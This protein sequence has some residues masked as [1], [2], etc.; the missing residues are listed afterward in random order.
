MNKE[1]VRKTVV[2][3]LAL[4]L[5]VLRAY[6]TVQNA[7]AQETSANVNINIDV[8][9]NA[10]ISGNAE[11]SMMIDDS[12]GF[13][14]NQ[15]CEFTN[16]S[17]NKTI[18]IFFTQQTADISLEVKATLNKSTVIAYIEI[19]VNDAIQHGINITIHPDRWEQ[20]I[21]GKEADFFG[22]NK[23]DITADRSLTMWAEKHNDSIS[24]TC[25]STD[26]SAAAVTITKEALINIAA[27]LNCNIS[28]LNI[29]YTGGISKIAMNS[30]ESMTVHIGHFSNQT[31]T[32][33]NETQSGI[34]GWLMTESY[35]GAPIWAWLLVTFLVIVIAVEAHKRR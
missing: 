10:S 33:T 4:L 20:K 24:I 27:L 11:I 15:F 25:N 28:E 30:D 3:A 26:S 21:T 32:F 2:I 14:Y 1:T 7:K 29:E 6:T 18:P 23:T 22:S 34:A 12:S 8:E 17:I 9:G 35:G 31:V 16:R 19:S 13:N 5:L